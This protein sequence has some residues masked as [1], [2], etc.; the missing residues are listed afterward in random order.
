LEKKIDGDLTPLSFTISTPDVPE[1]K[2]VAEILKRTWEALGAEI[3]VKVYE[4]G[5]ITHHVIRPR[6]YQVLIFGEVIGRHSD[7]YGFWHS[8]QRLDPGP[9]IALYTNIAVDR[10]LERA[11][12]TTSQEARIK[13]YTVFQN[14]VKEDVPAVFLY[15]PEFIYLTAPDVVNVDT[16]AASTGAE[17]FIGIQNWYVKT[18]KIWTFFNNTN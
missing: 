17:R 18:E 6:D 12:A 1:L 5:N 14:E 8:S 13:Q 3:E 7:P 9:N 16:I 4:E 15:A 11:R 10:A 2:Q